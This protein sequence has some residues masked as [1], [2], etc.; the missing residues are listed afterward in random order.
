M[1]FAAKCFFCHPLPHPQ[2]QKHHYDLRKS[3]QKDKADG[4]VLVHVC[5][6]NGRQKPLIQ[7]MDIS[8]DKTPDE[9]EDIY[10]YLFYFSS[11]NNRF[12]L[13]LLPQPKFPEFSYGEYSSSR[14]E[15]HSTG[16]IE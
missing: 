16:I 14:L 3:L 7:P 6:L 11:N 12:S 4:T 9:S 8:R 15:V 5:P 13:T 10:I 1:E 2:K